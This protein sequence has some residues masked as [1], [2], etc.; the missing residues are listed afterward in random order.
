M[1]LLGLAFPSPGWWP[2]AH[3]A[4][5]PMTLMASWA[6]RGKRLFWT[7]FV[8][9]YL[10]WLVML[11]W[12]IGVT[13]GGYAA[14]AAYMALY[15]PAFLLLWRLID[16]RH[17]WPAAITVPLVFVSLEYI[18]G[19]FLQGGMAWFG[20]GHSQAPYLPSH[21]NRWL[22]QVADLAGDWTIS[23]VVAATNGFIVDLIR[24]SL[25][26]SHNRS[27]L[28][29]L[30]PSTILWLLIF[31]GTLF[32][33][34]A[35]TRPPSN[36]TVPV[37]VIQTNISQN[38][39]LSPTTE[40]M[41]ADWQRLIELT[42]QAIAHD[43]KP[44]IIVWPET[45]VPFPVN[46][47]QRAVYER[48]RAD[49]TGGNEL[50]FHEAISALALEQ[51]VHLF[52]GSGAVLPDTHPRQRLNS[53]FHYLPTGEQS[54]DWY[55]KID[56]VPFGEYIPWVENWPWL[57]ALFL[58]Y[59]S[60]YGPGNDY[61]LTPGDRRV[62]FTVPRDSDSIRVTAPICF[63]DAF[64][65]SCLALCYDR[66]GKR[67]DIM[68]NLTNDGWYPGTDQG[69]QHVQMAA[70]RSVE[71]RVPMARSVNTGVSCFI[72]SNGRIVSIVEKEGRVQEVD[73]LAVHTMAIDSRST[74]FGKVGTGPVFVLMCV[75]FLLAAESLS[76]RP[77]F[78]GP[79]KR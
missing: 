78:R 77:S 54:P 71:N 25:T 12:L 7:S 56:R 48:Q 10:W 26:P 53:V 43:P 6:D 76:K 75:M 22:I 46:P 30:L 15:Y 61:S 60:P 38:N 74:L 72:D 55:S 8:A 66:S 40:Q 50:L 37:A 59:L 42:R 31:G 47:E 64:A 65:R 19:T 63:E 2:L 73:G 51:R 41:V 33:G 49:G 70:I 4:L 58:K 20:L 44:L 11:G 17:Q 39:K 57:K 52:V 36:N 68:L 14:L 29:A 27:R 23:F 79:P 24:A 21:G 13:G 1:L 18:R 69:L 45:V 16:R 5:V 32:Y 28:R 35:N 62:V 67:S 3:I 34:V 9:S